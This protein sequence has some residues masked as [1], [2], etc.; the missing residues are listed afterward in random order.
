MKVIARVRSDFSEKFGIP[1]QAGLVP[2][3]ASQI[4]F[5]P[6]YANEAAVS[7]LADFSHIWLIWNFSETERDTWL[8]TI[9][10]PRLKGKRKGV[11]ATR[12][13]MRPNPIGLSS[14]KLDRIEYHQKLGPILHILGADLLDDTPIYDIKPYI[15]QDVHPQAS[16]GFTNEN[17]EY[18]LE[19][20]LENADLTDF[21]NEKLPALVGVLSEDPRP[22]YHNDPTR[23]YGLTFSG[24]NIRFKVFAGE[25]QVISAVKIN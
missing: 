18:Q 25:V 7:G 6:E 17:S 9:R 13:P 1:R 2:E 24:F 15:P 5:E 12:S 16:F 3:L 20:C 19:V 14:V 11:F 4:V 8:P 21:P 10:P 23:I 22:H